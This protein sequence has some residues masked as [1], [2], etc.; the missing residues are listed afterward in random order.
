MTAQES[1]H[2]LLAAERADT[3]ALEPPGE[4]L[5]L[6]DA[7]GRERVVGELHGAG[8]V[9]QRLPVADQE[10]GHGE[11]AGRAQITRSRRSSAT[12]AGE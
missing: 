10:D 1:A 7:A 4:A 3:L 9:A 11:R 12:W 5:G 6:R 8:G 2:G